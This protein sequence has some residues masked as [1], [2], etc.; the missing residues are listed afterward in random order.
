MVWMTDVDVKFHII[1]DYQRCG[2]ESLF[3]NLQLDTITLKLKTDD[4]TKLKT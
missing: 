2:L 4:L 3:D 1:A